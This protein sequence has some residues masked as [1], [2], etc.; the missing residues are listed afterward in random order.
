MNTQ[1]IEGH[2]SIASEK[3]RELRKYIYQLTSNTKYFPARYRK[4][5][6]YRIEMPADI[7]L[8]EFRMADEIFP[9]SS[10]TASTRLIHNKQGLAALYT[11]DTLM[12]DA[13]EWNTMFSIKPKSYAYFSGLLYAAIKVAVGRIKNEEDVFSLK[14]TEKP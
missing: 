11:L 4:S 3:V 9:S 1:R 10:E 13:F 6:I 14:Y 7:A 8:T 12:A 5:F 2:E